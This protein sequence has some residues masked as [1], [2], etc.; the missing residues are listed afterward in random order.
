MNSPLPVSS[1]EAEG[2]LPCFCLI[3]TRCRPLDEHGNADE[4]ATFLQH[5]I[6]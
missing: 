1:L 3:G 4:A 5:A 6:V 2:C